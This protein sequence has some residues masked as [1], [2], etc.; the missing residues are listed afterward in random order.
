MS[1][2]TNYSET[3][4]V[5]LL[6]ASDHAAYEEIYKRYFHLVFIHCIRRL[7]DKE[8]VTD[9]VQDAF[10]KLWQKREEIHPET[11]VTGYLYTLVKNRILDYFGHQQVKAKYISS[12]RSF[13]S[14]YSGPRTDSLVREKDIEA[15]INKEIEALPAKMREIFVLSRK[16]QFSYKEIAEEL[17]TTENNVSKQVNNALR[18]LKVKLGRT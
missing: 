6:K 12:M 5:H 2:Y 9:F 18:I 10:I 3:E 16:A 8:Q 13:M 17:N 4:L 14:T 7:D 11:N 1:A 15:Q